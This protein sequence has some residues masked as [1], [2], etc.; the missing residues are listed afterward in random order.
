MDIPGA[1]ALMLTHDTKAVRDAASIGEDIGAGAAAGSGQWYDSP[2]GMLHLSKVRGTDIRILEAVK[3]S[4]GRD[5]WGARLEPLFVDPYTGQ[6]GGNRY[7]GMQLT[8]RIAAGGMLNARKDAA[9]KPAKTRLIHRT[10]LRRRIEM[11]SRASSSPAQRVISEVWGALRKQDGTFS[12]SA[13]DEAELCIWIGSDCPAWARKEAGARLAIVLAARIQARW[14]GDPGQASDQTVCE[15]TRKQDPEWIDINPHT[16]G[17]P[18]LHALSYA[19]AATLEEVHG[20]WSALP[21]GSRPKHPLSPILDSWHRRPAPVVTRQDTRII[22]VLRIQGET[23]L[24]RIAGQ[25]FGGVD[26]GPARGTPLVS[27]G[28]GSAVR[29]TAGPH[30][31]GHRRRS[32][33]TRPIARGTSWR[34]PRGESRS[35][36][37]P[38]PFRARPSRACHLSHCADRR[39]NHARRVQD[40]LRHRQRLA[41][42]RAGV[43]KGAFADNHSAQWTTLVFFA[44]AVVAGHDP[45]PEGARRQHRGGPDALRHCGTRSGAATRHDRRDH[46][47]SA[48]SRQADGPE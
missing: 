26:P 43:E 37:R 14:T 31:P 11:A 41:A 25:H 34:P 32:A 22:P 46:C 42:R 16:D 10:S 45:H 12:G 3:S 29:P 35:V 28:G 30:R 23:R 39:G 38:G 2:R 21:Q 7:A 33:G 15:P 47:G 20:M 9:K 6:A 1:A 24:P 48:T 17:D 4:Y 40:E 18:R 19:G 27:S 44:A 8:G 5:G 36:D 13:P